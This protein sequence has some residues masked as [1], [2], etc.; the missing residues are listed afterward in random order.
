M[1]HY[2]LLENNQKYD[3]KKYVL[4]QLNNLKLGLQSLSHQIYDKMQNIDQ[5]VCGLTDGH[6]WQL[7][8]F[9]SSTYPMAN[10]PGV[11]IFECK[12]CREIIMLRADERKT[13]KKQFKI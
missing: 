3:N 1:L 13:W 6:K 9:D 12:L 10:P 8:S 5:A 4:K 7:K 11:F 2:E